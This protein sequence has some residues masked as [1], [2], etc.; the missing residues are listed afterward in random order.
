MGSGW[1]RGCVGGSCL[2]GESA[3]SR[4]VLSG[5][6]GCG[7]GAGSWAAGSVLTPQF[8]PQ[9]VGCGWLA[10]A[11]FLP[12]SSHRCWMSGVG[13]VMPPQGKRSPTGGRCGGWKRGW[14]GRWGSPAWWSHLSPLPLSAVRSRL[15][16]VLELWLQVA[17][18]GGG[19]LQGSGP[20]S[21]ALLGHMLSDIMPPTDSI[22]VRPSHLSIPFL[23][24]H[25]RAP[26]A[27]GNHCLPRDSTP[28]WTLPTCPCLL[29]GAP[30]TPL[31][32]LLPPPPPRCAP[33]T[34]ACPRGASPVPPRSQS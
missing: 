11:A 15:Y 9:G 24:P 25:P 28:C 22:K 17:G 27:P 4:W 29:R 18:A 23:H 19:V 20:L 16:Q 2:G 26:A 1:G 32:P 14:V 5:A 30:L 10:G 33:G 8:P 31:S 34:I 21:E 13:P 3:R 6:G 12:A 7:K